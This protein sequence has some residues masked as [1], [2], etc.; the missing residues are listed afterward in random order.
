MLR[1]KSDAAAYVKRF[2]AHVNQDLNQ[3]YEVEEIRA[4][5]TDACS[6][7]KNGIAER[8]NCSFQKM[9]HGF[10]GEN[11]DTLTPSNVK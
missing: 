11:N 4:Q 10:S 5:F 3:F 2:G 1:Q 9:A 8:K 7:Q 6:P